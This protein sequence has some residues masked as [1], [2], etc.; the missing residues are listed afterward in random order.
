M[1]KILIAAFILL[2]SNFLFA[3][4]VKSPVTWTATS[5]KI[6]D[7]TYEIH[8]T[9]NIQDAWHI[10][11]QTTPEGGPVPTSITFTKNPL[12]INEGVTK[13]V[14]KLEQHNEPLFGVDVK[15]FSNKVDFVQVVKLKANVKTSVDIAVEFMTCNDRECLPP[16]T[17]KFTVA[18]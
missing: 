6:G 9:A 15:Q 10:Y 8:L 5:K 3:Q 4:I 13:E 1:K 14:G 18:L 16:S 12:V 7:K 2:S 11:S 17:K